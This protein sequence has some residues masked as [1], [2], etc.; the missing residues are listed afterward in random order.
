MKATLF[1]LLC[2]V[3]LAAGP[4]TTPTGSVLV[5]ENENTLEGQIERVGDGYRVRRLTGDTWLPA[6]TALQLCANMREAYA[7]VRGRANLR[8]PDERLRLARW[9]HDRGLRAEA[10]AEVRAAVQLRPGH[11][12]SRHMLAMLEQARARPAAP[13]SPAPDEGPAPNVDVTAD[14][15]SQFATR[16]Q[17]VLMNACA[18]CHNLSHKGPFRLQRTYELG[19]AGSRTTQRNLATVLAQVSF[20]QP[21][22]SPLLTRAVSDHGHTGQPP[23]RSRQATAYRLLDDW[24]RLTIENNPQLREQAAPTAPPTSPAPMAPAVPA[25]GT[26][27]W[28]AEA[29]PAAAAPAAPVIVPGRPGA[30]PG[31]VVSTPSVAPMPAPAVPAKPVGPPDPYDPDDFNRMAHPDRPGAGTKPRGP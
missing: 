21:Q 2:V 22:F 7:F 17:P 23:L 12:E 19:V 27:A 3:L 1:P 20:S 24:V 10:I 25:G 5:L 14:C 16:V 6:D 31:A 4:A 28:G 15:L 13:Q 8:D 30:P 29:G 26:S 9:C 11:V 18:S